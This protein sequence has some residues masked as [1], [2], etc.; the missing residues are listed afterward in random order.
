METLF[1]LAQV[2][3]K[4]PNMVI[5]TDPEGNIEYI[6][7]AFAEMSGYR[8]DEAIGA[9]PRILRSEQ[10]PR[11]R[12]FELWQTIKRGKVWRGE[13]CNRH[14]N[15]A[16]YWNFVSISPLFNEQGDI[17]HFISVQVDITERKRTEMA[18]RESEARLSAIAN[19]IPDLLFVLDEDGR[20]IEV[21]TSQSD[22]LNRHAKILKGKL[23]TEAHG[24][25]KAAFLLA[26]IRKALL[27]RQIQVAE[28]ELQVL[29]G[30]RWFE[31]RTAP[32]DLPSTHKP[33]VIVVARDITARKLAEERLRQSQKLEAIGHLTGGVAHDF[34]N[35][36]AIIL[37][38]L[39]LMDELLSDRPDLQD[40]VRRAFG[41]AQRGALL[42][43]RLLAFSRQQPLQA[44]ATDINQL[45]SRMIDILRRTLGET[46]QL[47]AVLA[48]DLWSVFVDPG[49]LENALLNLC[50]NARD[51][52]PR[53]GRLKI[54]AAN[55]ELESLPD[56]VTNAEEM[57]PGQYVM[58]AV[59]DSG[60]G[61]TPEV[62]EHAFEP[63]FTTKEVG[64]GS[65][66]GLSMVYGFVKQSGG[67]VAID[68][69]AGQGATIRMYLPRSHL[70][71]L[72]TI[73]TRSPKP[74]PPGQ[75]ETILVV[76]DDAT[77][78]QLTVSM[79]HSL[80]Y[81]TLE[82]GTAE[83]ALEKLAAHRQVSLLFT[84]V[85]L[86]GG[87]NGFDLAALVQQRYPHLKVLFTSGYA[88]HGLFDSGDLREQVELLA[89]P[90]RRADLADKLQTILKKTK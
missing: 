49:Q 46:I 29:S 51:A 83:V 40:L 34:N 45:V 72:P 38:N 53:G 1:R 15:G 63:F 86:P 78:R 9:N 22:L 23:L 10:T 16:L 33:A 76:E 2:V 87:M 54:N 5:I 62:V 65:G 52:M 37:G 32:I 8:P 31:S 85:V 13:L 47:Q 43:Q 11:Q 90:Y 74:L 42:T 48:N 89:K 70:E 82:A 24:P 56:R 18:L 75:A 64:K 27:T 6:N 77:V 88:E 30:Q 61:M 59:N 84:D 36:L 66:L 39:E 41:A 68:S 73:D 14:K 25:E 26:I 79:I 57:Q 28:Y 80:G 20:Y 7:P 44:R 3:E 67:H 55:Y 4:T 19:A 69:K 60:M 35:L 21:L 50:L 12:F 58:L 81:Q 17:S 71:A